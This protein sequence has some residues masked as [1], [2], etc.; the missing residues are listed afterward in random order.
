MNEI[1]LEIIMLFL[2]RNGALAKLFCLLS[3]YWERLPNH[4]R[5]HHAKVLEQRLQ[6]KVS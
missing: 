6:L 1:I 5:Y 3:S 2:L 4:D